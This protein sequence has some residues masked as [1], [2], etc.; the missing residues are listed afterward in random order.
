[1]KEYNFGIKE[2]GDMKAVVLADNTHIVLS[3][4]NVIIMFPKNKFEQIFK[5]QIDDVKRE[6]IG[7]SFSEIELDA[8]MK[9]LERLEES[10]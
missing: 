10:K 9:G 8:I 5:E 1:M 2:N 6:F 7:I 3:G 4:K